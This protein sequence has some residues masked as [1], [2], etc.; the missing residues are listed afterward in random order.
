M[1]TLYAESLYLSAFNNLAQASLALGKWSF[2]ASA[3]SLALKKS[4][5]SLP[6]NSVALLTESQIENFLVNG[7]RES[8]VSIIIFS[9]KEKPPVALRNVALS[10]LKFAQIGFVSGPSIEL[11]QRFGIKNKDLPWAIG[12]YYSEGSAAQ[13]ESVHWEKGP[14]AKSIEEP[15]FRVCVS[16]ATIL[17]L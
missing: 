4:Y 6:E 17:Y 9:A 14:S 7:H 12:A 16:I 3:F 5:D 8:V 1:K 15:G 13:D 10:S 2:D 11:L